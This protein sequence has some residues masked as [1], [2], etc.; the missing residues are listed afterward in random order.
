M[1]MPADKDPALL[2]EEGEKNGQQMNKRISL[3]VVLLRREMG[4]ETEQEG[5]R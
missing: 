4:I 1:Y 3:C 5:W 2:V